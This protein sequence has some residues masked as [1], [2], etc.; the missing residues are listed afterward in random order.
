MPA[1]SRKVSSSVQSPCRLRPVFCEQPFPQ[2]QVT[3]LFV[4]LLPFLVFYALAPQ[5][6]LAA[7]GERLLCRF[8]TVIEGP[9]E[10]A[11]VRWIASGAGCCLVVSEVW[12]C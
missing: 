5:L 9:L 2:L 4:S 3:S 12:C 11:L 1:L 7:S 8:P 10:A 6:A